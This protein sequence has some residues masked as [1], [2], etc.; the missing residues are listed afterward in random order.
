MLCARE[1]I[2]IENI[3]VVKRT[4]EKTNLIDN[5]QFDW[6]ATKIGSMN[7]Y[8][9]NKFCCICKIYNKIH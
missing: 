5:Q 6:I 7:E 4:C 1:V 8:K 9:L 2:I 3:L